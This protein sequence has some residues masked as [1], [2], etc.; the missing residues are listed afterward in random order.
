MFNT[1][2]YWVITNNLLNRSLRLDSFK[3]TFT[4]QTS[5]IEFS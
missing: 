2:K 5:K 1:T 3:N 4:K